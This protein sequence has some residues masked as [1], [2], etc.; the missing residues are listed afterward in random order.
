MGISKTHPLA[1]THA[2]WLVQTTKNNNENGY[3]VGRIVIVY[4]PATD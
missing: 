4:P 2:F 3:G 1:D